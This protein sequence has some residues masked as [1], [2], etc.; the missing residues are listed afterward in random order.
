MPYVHD[1]FLNALAN[2]AAT[3]PDKIVL[4]DETQAGSPEV[5]S[6]SAVYWK[7]PADGEATGTI[8]PYADVGFTENLV[9][10]VTAGETVTAW[11][12]RETDDSEAFGGD[13]TNESYASDGEFT[14][15]GDQT[16]LIIEL[17]TE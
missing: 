8:R 12:A 7:T 17:K 15:I 1:D 11:R 3:I 16:G 14:L 2:H 4:I 13:L 9:F 10:N 5:D 6:I